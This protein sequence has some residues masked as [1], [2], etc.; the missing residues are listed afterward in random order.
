M[1]DTDTGAEVW[2]FLVASTSATKINAVTTAA[3]EFF[4]K[5]PSSL[6]GFKKPNSDPLVSPRLRVRVLGL[7][8][9]SGIAEQ[10]VGEKQTLEGAKNRL[11]FAKAHAAEVESKHTPDFFVSIE[12]G[13]EE[14]PQGAGW[15][16]YALIIIEHAPSGTQFVTRSGSVSYDEI[17]VRHAK[18]KGFDKTTVGDALA[19]RVTERGWVE[20]V[21]CSPKDPQLYLTGGLM[22]RQAILVH[23]VLTGVAQLSKKLRDE[24]QPSVPA[25]SPTTATSTDA[26]A[27]AASQQT[28]SKKQG[29]KEKPQAAAPK[30]EQAAK[31]A[32]PPSPAGKKAAAKKGKN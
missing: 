5:M 6:S 12:N 28:P 20:Y 15:I 25:V 4:S 8:A 2:T 7:D 21:P 29:E 10:P 19:E 17:D 32:P 22:G 11:A 9:K 30:T 26:P 3:Q 16:D 27:P 18:Q 13:I 1:A 24:A 14:M 31:K 23:A